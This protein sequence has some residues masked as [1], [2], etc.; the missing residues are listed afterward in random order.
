MIQHCAYHPPRAD[1]RHRARVAAERAGGALPRQQQAHV[2]AGR[3]GP[4]AP[5]HPGAG[6]APERQKGRGGDGGR[7][8][9][10]SFSSV[11]GREALCVPAGSLLLV[12]GDEA[13]VKCSEMS[14]IFTGNFPWPAS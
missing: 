1:P 10:L 11:R 8:L 7:P 3:R 5:H 2:V 13:S 14:E 6:C 12:G 9:R 4:L